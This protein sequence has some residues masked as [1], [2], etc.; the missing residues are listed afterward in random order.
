MKLS[1][2]M[3]NN[4]FMV[5][6]NRGGEVRAEPGE[7]L[8]GM[9]RALYLTLCL[10]FNER[11]Y[12]LLLQSVLVWTTGVMLQFQVGSVME[13]CWSKRRKMVGAGYPVGLVFIK[14]HSSPSC[15][16]SALLLLTI[17]QV[18]SYT[19]GNPELVTRYLRHTHFCYLLFSFFNPPNCFLS[20]NNFCL[21]L[22][23]WIQTS[24]K[25]LAVSTKYAVLIFF[26]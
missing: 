21:Q 10:W 14:A 8:K 16:S 25:C 17:F 6:N 5:T 1:P 20:S 19:N 26:P 12:K 2:L 24:E 7:D 15:L 11:A 13:K 22:E 18:A 3:G 23:L 4:Y 9:T